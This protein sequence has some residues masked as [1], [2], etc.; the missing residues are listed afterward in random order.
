[1]ERKGDPMSEANAIDEVREL[2]LQLRAIG[3]WQCDQVCQLTP[4]AKLLLDAAKWL[5]ELSENV[6]CQGYIGCDGGHGC[7][8]DHK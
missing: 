2:A 3:Q 6:C 8:S 4:S 7:D 1:M 5:D